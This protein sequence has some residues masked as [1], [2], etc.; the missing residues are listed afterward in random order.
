MADEIIDFYKKAKEPEEPQKPIEE[1]K[2]TTVPVIPKPDEPF[3]RFLL[4]LAEKLQKEKVITEKQQETF[5]EQIKEPVSTNPNENDPFKKFI[6]S[7]ANI[8]KEDQLVNREENIKE[9]TISFINKLKEQ[10]E[11]PFIIKDEPVVKTKK[12]K[13]LPTTIAKKVKKLPQTIKKEEPVVKEQADEPV[14]EQPKEEN[15][16]VKELKTSDKTNKK[17]PEKIKSV[18]D[19]KSIVEKQVAE[20][21]SRYPNLGFTGGG[22]GTNAVQYAKG[23]TMDGD[24]NVTGT[25]NASTYLSGNVNL[26]DIFSSFNNEADRLISGSSSL[27]LAP[28]G[29]IEFPN[30]T[31]RSPNET[32]LTLESENPAL[33]SYTRVALSPYAFFAYDNEGNS[34]TF[35][36]VDNAIVLTSQDEHEWTFN[37][38]GILVGP[39]GA[40]TVN[41]LSSL[42]RILSAGVPLHDI[43]LTSETDAQTLE[44]NEISELLSIS[45]GNT[46]SLSSLSDKSYANSNFLRLS[47]GIISGNLTIQGNISALGTATFTNTIFTTTSALSVVNTGPGPGLYVFQAAGPYDVASFYD[48]DGIE[49]LHVGNAGPGGFGKVGVNESFPNEELTVRGSISATDTIHANSYLSGGVDLLDIFGGPVDRLINGS[50][51]V[52]LSSNGDLALPGAIV[53][54][55]NSKLDLIGYGPNTAYLTTT[56]DDSTAL[57]MGA[58]VAELRANSYVSIS[59]NT[60]GTTH[61]WEFGADGSLKFPDNT[62]QTT[63]FTGNPDSSNWDSTYTTVKDISGNW[64]STYQTVCA[65]SALWEE[66][67]EILPTVTNYLSTNLVT[68]SSL[69]VTQKLLSAGTD[70]FDIF[71]TSE[72]DSQTLLFNE[73]TKDLSI[74][75]GNT[76]SLSALIDYETAFS[77]SSAKY[78]SVYTTVQTNSGGWSYQGTDLKELSSNWQQAYTNLVTNSAAYLTSVDLTFLQEP[79]ANWNVAYNITTTYSTTSSTFATNTTVG[80]LTSQLLLTSIYENVSG[81][82]QSTYQT[83]CALSAQWGNGS[84][85]LST[86]LN[87]LSTN[88]ITLSTVTLNP[89]ATLSSANFITSRILQDKLGEIISVKDFGARGNGVTNDWLALQRALSAAAGIARV[90]IPQGLYIISQELRIPSNSYIYG[91]GI[92]TTVIKLSSTANAT[93][94]VMTNSQ[95]T[96]SVLT[97]QG[98]ENIV[99]KD[100]E[101][102]GNV[103]RFPGSY[104]PNGDASGT[105]LCFAYVKNALVERVSVHDTCRHCIDIGAPETTLNSDPLEYTPN[106]S[107]NIHLKDII[108]YGAGDDNITTHFSHNIIIENAYVPYTGGTEVATNSNGIEIDDGSYDVTIIGGYI[109]NCRRGLEVK[110]HS[111]AP[112]AKRIRVYGLT[113]ENCVRNF[114]IRH[115]GFDNTDSKTAFD[116][117]LYDCTSIAPVSSDQ[118]TDGPRSL[119]ISNYDGVYVKD[120]KVV[121]EHNASRAVTIQERARNVK[122]DGMTFTQISGSVTGITDALLYID[123]T[124]RRN[125]TLQNLAFRDCVGLPIYVTGN[126]PGIVIDSVDAYTTVSPGVSAVIDFT[127]A[128]TTVPYSIKNVSYSGYNYAYTL[129]GTHN[130]DYVLPSNVGLIE[131]IVPTSPGTANT[132]YTV[133]K[134]GWRE[135]TAQDIGEGIGARIEFTGNIVSGVSANNDVPVAFIETEKINGTDS[136]LS[137]RLTFG[138]RPNNTDSPVTRMS[139]TPAGNVGIG[140]ITPNELLTVTGNISGSGNLSVRGPILSAG[141]DIR[142]LFGSGGGSDT[143]LRTFVQTNSANWVEPIRQFDYVVLDSVSYNYCGTAPQGSLTSSSTWTIKR[144]LFTSAGTLLSSGTVN[145]SI[146]D[147]RYTYSY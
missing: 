118:T 130:F 46:V 71:L 91:A 85:N 56:P 94:C 109:K 60:G 14:K 102:D 45:N 78:E 107:F 7:F 81:N 142:T 137:S 95:N 15:T 26:A 54:A 98:N 120:F 96:R 31:I 97:N 101:L 123:S 111:Y 139:I 49:V 44:F 143:E 47:G 113:V 40:L 9:A 119:Q 138:T 86:V 105:G 145:N 126:I 75:N 110:G 30:D 41:S 42:G 38:Q 77:Q 134:F 57:F 127:W 58:N 147:N 8:L 83:V 129:G 89:V 121:G 117:A 69:N 17:I 140:T 66:S 64:Q 124:T 135:G 72:T 59:T 43:F 108:A 39:H 5:V 32:I 144:L 92:G 125:V 68:I 52:V 132:Q 114:G 80:T 63:A 37:K 50:Y 24:L 106:P 55:S 82:W 133:A 93:Q 112:A 48:G 28:D 131:N 79:S 128:P 2:E 13:Y 53:T 73:S 136:D 11:E 65:L 104:S 61:L 25:V 122:I 141:V 36:E 27:V 84:V 76:V 70:L 116:V 18:S 51:Q 19:V 33:S 74:S 20:I 29:S 100:L 115:L 16:Y 34:I 146:W 35:D 4:E 90:Y 1:Q 21:L 99:I 6:G 23:G 67:A 88:N 3:D 62:T 103:S 10:P 12:Q 22:G 87:H